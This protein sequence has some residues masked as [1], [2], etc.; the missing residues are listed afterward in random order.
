MADNELKECVPNK[1]DFDAAIQ[2]A[3]P[4]IEKELRRLEQSGVRITKEIITRKLTAKVA[5]FAHVC[6]ATRLT[7]FLVDDGSLEKRWD[8]AT[9]KYKF[10]S[11][12]PEFSRWED[13]LKARMKPPDPDLFDSI[14]WP[15]SL[16]VN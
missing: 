13:L 7:Q 11:L 6:Y 8:P 2:M 16:D 14:E 10:R 3:V 4:M 9:Q 5:E 15:D 12:N 1:G